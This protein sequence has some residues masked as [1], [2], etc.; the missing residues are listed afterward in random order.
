MVNVRIENEGATAELPGP[1]HELAV[2]RFK[3]WRRLR[4]EV[5]DL[6]QSLEARD[7]VERAKRTLMEEEHLTERQAYLKPQSKGRSRRLPMDKVAE[8]LLARMGR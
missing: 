4:E 7:V 8:H 6:Y 3:E 1:A 5:Q 2:N